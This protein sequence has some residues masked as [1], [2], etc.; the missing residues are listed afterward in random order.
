[1]SEKHLSGTC[2]YCSFA[3]SF[4]AGKNPG[5]GSHFLLQRIFPDPGTES[6]SPALAGGFFITE[7]P[8][9][10]LGACYFFST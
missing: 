5:V 3:K 6:A 8:G 2:C 4:L 7:P 9:K 10:L 1:M